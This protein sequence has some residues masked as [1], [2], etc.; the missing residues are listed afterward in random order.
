MSNDAILK[1]RED[2]FDRVLI[3]LMDLPNA[4]SVQ[5]EMD[6]LYGPFKSA[7]Y[8]RHEKVVQAKL[9]SSGLAQR[10]GDQ[11]QGTTLTLDFGD[12]AT[13]VNGDPDN[14]I[15]KRSF[16]C[17]FTKTKILSLWAKIGF[18]PCTCNCHKNPNVRRAMGQHTRDDEV[19]E[20]LQL[21]HD[22]SV[23]NVEAVG[24]NF[25]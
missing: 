22:V 4:T 11:Q 20:S 18:V 23:D 1:K 5:Q 12:L 24:F 13:I 16:V 2:L 7:T 17:H 19:L 14:T 21:R 3:I 8:A 10:N 9:R 6:A 15:K 25:G